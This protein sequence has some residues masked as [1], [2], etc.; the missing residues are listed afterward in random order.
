MA[1]EDAKQA[2]GQEIHRLHDHIARL[3]NA[4]RHLVG[5]AQ[6]RNGKPAGSK[7]NAPTSRPKPARRKRAST[8]RRLSASERQE[9]IISIVKKRPGISQSDLAKEAGV[10]SSHVSTILKTL[11]GEKKL[12]RGDDGLLAT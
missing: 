5:R 10:T 9:Q 3:E 11:E 8:R 7:A 2:I 4:L 12:R 1:L 6:T